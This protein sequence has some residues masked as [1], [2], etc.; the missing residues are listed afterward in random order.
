L[1]V[2]QGVAYQ[3]TQGLKPLHACLHA[4]QAALRQP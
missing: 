4:V 1:R 3:A 2:A